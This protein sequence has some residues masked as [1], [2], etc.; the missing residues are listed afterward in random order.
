MRLLAIDTSSVACSAAVLDG[1]AIDAQFRIEPR[2]HTRILLPMIRRLLDERGLETKDLDAVVLGNGPGSF[3]GMRIA[4]SVAQGICFGSGLPLVP[5]SSLLAVA[6][7]V[8]ECEGADKVAV[9]QDARMNEVY[10]A[11]Y[12]ADASGLPEAIRAE[13][14]VPAGRR[15]LLPAAAWTAAGGGWQQYPQ[16]RVACAD[17]IRTF[18]AVV[19]PKARYLL[20]TG[21]RLLRAGSAI[22]A[23]RLEPAYLRNKVAEPEKGLQP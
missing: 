12:V 9:A 23:G 8:M 6:A 15:G 18:S 21:A 3:I 4:A 7:E 17:A 22:D 10:F 16:L 2:E 11:A 20:K 13:A 5:V 19:H 1:D 14:I